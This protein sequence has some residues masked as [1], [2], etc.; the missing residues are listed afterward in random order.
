MKKHLFIAI[1]SILAAST[2]GMGNAN[3]APTISIVPTTEGEIKLT[4]LACLGG[5]VTCID[6]NTQTTPYKVTTLAY[7]KNTG[8]SRL[9]SDKSGTANNWGF[10][11]NFLSTDAGT[12][13]PVGESIFR[14]VA[15]DTSGTPIEGGQ[16]ETGRFKFDFGKVLKQVELS[17]VDTEANGTGILE[18]NGS[19]FSQLLTPGAND[20]LHKFKLNNVSSFIVQLGNHGRNDGVVLNVSVPEANNVLGIAGVALVGGAMVIKRK[21]NPVNAQ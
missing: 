1:S 9:F 21:R 14:P 17:F 7:D 6:T 11:I 4:N 15:Y 18:L 3:A 19:P 13:A 16:L 12:N 10:G 20:N 2:I 8:L 5:T